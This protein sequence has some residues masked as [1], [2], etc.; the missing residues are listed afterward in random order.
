MNI[1]NSSKSSGELSMN[2]KINKNIGYVSI[3]LVITAMLILSVGFFAMLNFGVLSLDTI[4]KSLG[5]LDA[6]N[7]FGDNAAGSDYTMSMNYDANGYLISLNVNPADINP[8]SDF[9]F[10][11]NDSG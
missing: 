11:K 3:E 4:T 6:L 9:L 1:L 10:V 8:L 5:K 7:I 2:R